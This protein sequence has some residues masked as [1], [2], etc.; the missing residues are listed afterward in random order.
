MI[1]QRGVDI[2][3]YYFFDLG[4]RWGRV[5]NARPR[6]RNPVPVVW[7]DTLHVKNIKKTPR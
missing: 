4:A 5:V 6:E 1:A 3:L 2:S 7:E